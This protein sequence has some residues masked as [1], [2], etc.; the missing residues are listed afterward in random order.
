MALI[1]VQVFWNLKRNNFDKFQ[2]SSQFSFSDDDTTRW[3]LSN[4][5]C[6]SSSRERCV[7]FDTRTSPQ[8]VAL[9]DKER[10]RT[11][12]FE[13]VKIFFFIFVVRVRVVCY[14][15]FVISVHLSYLSLSTTFQ[16]F[17]DFTGYY[18]ASDRYLHKLQELKYSLSLAHM[19]IPFTIIVVSSPCKDRRYLER[20]QRNFLS[21]QCWLR[22]VRSR[23]SVSCAFF[24]CSIIVACNY[25][26]T[27]TCSVL[28]L[29]GG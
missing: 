29:S 14:R 18:H 24:R 2:H 7:Q 23:F 5:S 1:I 8:L 20:N 16:Q 11:M 9:D 3:D 21:Q 22:F 6:R 19:W 28:S 15:G 27:I 4:L 10:S 26:I 13:M 12:R 25:S 17:I